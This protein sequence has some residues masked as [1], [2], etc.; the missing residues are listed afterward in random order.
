MKDQCIEYT[1]ENISYFSR[2][3]IFNHIKHSEQVKEIYHIESEESEEQEKIEPEIKYENESCPVCFCEYTTGGEDDL[4]NDKELECYGKC[5]HKLCE[6][7]YGT[8][9]CSNNSR[10]PVC[11]EVWDDEIDD[12]SSR[13]T[14]ILWTE[15]DIDELCEAEDNDT[16]YRIIDVD[17][18]VDTLINDGG[19]EE[20]L[21]YDTSVEVGG[22]YDT[23]DKYRELSGGGYEYVV[24]IRKD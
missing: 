8:I 3:T 17:E 18:L 19:Y 22:L 2:T 11:R 12:T 7:C 14:E 1:T 10:C 16:L 5:G 6:P 13:D 20:I 4:T 15:E 23:P 21:G 24:M 9:T